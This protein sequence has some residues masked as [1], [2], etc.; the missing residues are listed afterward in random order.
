MVMHR[1]RFVAMVGMALVFGGDVSLA[2]AAGCKLETVATWPVRLERNKLLVEGAIN[3]QPARI[4]LDT[5]AMRTLLFREAANRFNVVRSDAKRARMFGVG[6]ESKVEIAL[7]DEFRVGEFTRKPW[8]MTISGDGD[9][10]ADVLLGADFLTLVDIEFDL[11]HNVIRLFQAHD[12]DGKKLAYWATTAASINEV[13][14][15]AIQLSRPQI[16]MDVKVNDTQISA[17]LDSG[18][19]YTVIDKPAAARVGVTPETP[20]VVVAGKTTGLGGKVLP[21]WTGKFQ[22]F[23]IG[24]ETAKDVQIRFSELFR[25]ANYA[26]IGHL[27]P[28]KVEGL[29]QMLIGVDFLRT[30]RVLVAHSQR[31]MYFTHNGGPVFGSSPPME[32]NVAPASPA[33]VPPAAP[34]K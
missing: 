2:F 23:T 33:E 22:T 26:S 1:A 14:I 15:D 31:R 19:S 4:M 21:V 29:Q 25:D 5:G 12:C 16:V 28:T 32:A 17:E 30:H 3:G 6:G 8:K 34:A 7:L 24:T 18:A 10:G 20:G 27:V 11:E 13:A 9:F